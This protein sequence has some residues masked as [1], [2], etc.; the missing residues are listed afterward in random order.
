RS[1]ATSNVYGGTTRLWEIASGRERVRFQGHR[2]GVAALAYAGDGSLLASGGWDHTVLIWDV[3]GK[4]A[5]SRQRRGDLDGDSLTALW[6]DLASTDASKAFQAIQPLVSS[7]QAVPFLKGQLRPAAAG[8]QKRI[9]RLIA[10]L[11]NESFAVREKATQG[12]LEIGEPSEPALQ[13]KLAGKP[14]LE[15]RRRAEAI[16]A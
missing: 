6:T 12:L 2:G 13:T 4:M 5:S 8:D 7:Q 16:L 15:V 1:L 3:L 9:A 14:S 10:D 11:D